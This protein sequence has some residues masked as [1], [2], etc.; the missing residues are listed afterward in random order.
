M[1]P[2]RILRR[3]YT[4]N[5]T[6]ALNKLTTELATDSP[7][8]IQILSL[9]EQVQS[10][11]QRLFD[12]ATQMQEEMDDTALEA[13]IE[14]MDD[15]ENRV[16][17]VKVKAQAV[18]NQM[19]Q[20]KV[21]PTQP[22]YYQPPVSAKLPDATLQEFHGDVEM[23]PSFIDQFNAL[24]DNNKNLT[25]VEKFSYLRGAAK[26]EIIQHYP[27]TSSNYQVALERL[28]REFGDENL[29][30]KKHLN[31]LLDMSKRKQP[32]SNQEIQEFYNFLE[33]K[34]TCL[35]ALNKPVDQSNEMLITLI[36]RQLPKKLKVQIAK[37]DAA[38]NTVQSVMNI[39]KDYINTA[40][41]ME[42]REECEIDSDDDMYNHKAAGYYKHKT[43]IDRDSDEDEG[44]ITS[45]AAALP[46]LTQKRRPCT[47]CHD[48]HS[49]SYC[50]KV[51]NIEQRRQVLWRENRCFNCLAVGHR[52]TDCRNDGRCQT[53]QGKHHS[54]LC[55]N[56]LQ[57]KYGGKETQQMQNR[58]QTSSNQQQQ[59]Y[60]GGGGQNTWGRKPTSTNTGVCTTSSWE[61][62]NSVLLELAEAEIRKPGSSKSITVNV[63][64]DHGAQKSYVKTA[65]RKELALDGIRRDVLEHSVFGTEETQVSSS[66]FVMLEIVKGSF[67][68]EIPV[69]VSNHICNPLPSFKISSRKLQELKGVTLA[70]PRC[71]YEESH[72]ISVLIGGDLYWEF[73]GSKQIRTSFG[74]CA[75]QSKL[76]WLL[77]GP[78]SGEEG[79]STNVYLTTS[80]VI[81]SMKLDEVTID[82]K[83]VKQKLLNSH[84]NTCLDKLET[85]SNVA[86]ATSQHKVQGQSSEH[87]VVPVV[88]Q[89]ASQTQMQ[90]PDK[91]NAHKIS[92]LSA[93][94]MSDNYN[95]VQ[96]QM[97][98][99]VEEVDDWFQYKMQRSLTDSDVELRWF[100]ETE[101]IA[102]I[103][104][105]E[106]PSVLEEF[107][108]NIKYDEDT[109][110]YTVG[111]PSKINMLEGL[112]D[113][114][115]ICEIR[116]QSLLNKLNK[117]GNEETRKAYNEIIKKQLDEGIIEE[118]SPDQCTDAV[119]HY[120]PHHAVLRK[121][122]QSSK[123]RIVYD[124]SAKA[125]RESS[126]L[127]QCLKPGPSLVNNLVAVL[128]MFRM[129]LIGVVADICQAYLQLLLSLND[130]D[131]TRFLWKDGGDLNNPT[132]IFRFTRVPF[133]LTSSP[134][135]LHATLIHHLNKYKEGY[136]EIVTKLLR[137]IYVDDLV[138]GAD[139]EDEVVELVNQGDVIIKEAN[140]EFKKWRSNSPHVLE[141]S[142]VPD[143]MK[144]SEA[145]IKVLGVTWNTN[146]DQFTYEV[147][148]IIDLAESL[149]PCKRTVLRIL[150]KVYDPLGMLSP[151]LITAKVL[152][153]ML[154]RLNLSWDQPLEEDFIGLWNRWVA[155]LRILKEFK[156]PRCI[157]SNAHSELELVGF[158]DASKDAY[159]A[160]VYLRCTTK[161]SIT[162]N[163][164]LAKSRVA[165]MKQLTIPRL[166]LLGAV[167]LA[168]MISLL[169]EIL[170]NWKFTNV[171]HYT[172]SMN[173][174]GWIQSE[175]K[176]N[177]YITKRLDEIL[178]LSSKLKWYHCKGEENPADYPTRGMTMDQLCNSTEWL[179][180]PQ[181]LSTA[182]FSP[183]RNNT[184]IVPSHE[185]L[186]EEIKQVHTH[187]VIEEAGL[188]KLIKLD[189]YSNLGRLYR[190][191]AYVYLFIKQSQ[192]KEVSLIDMKRLA[193]TKWIINQQMK[194]N[195]NLVPY[196]KGDVATR[197]IN[198]AKQLD[199]FLDDKGIMRCSGRFKYANLCYRLK[200]P[201]FMPR[202]SHLTT[203]IIRDR[204]RRVKHAGV[205]TTLA[206]VR[207]DYWI[208]RGRRFIQTIIRNCVICRR[209]TAKPFPAP[210]P[211]PLPKIRLSEMPPFTNT[212]VDFAGP[213]YCRERGRGKKPYKSYIS[214]YTCASARAI[215]L[216]LVPNMSASSFKNSM[217]RFVSTRGIPHC[218]VSDN[219]KS[220]K[221]TAEDLNCIIT[222]SPTKE[223]IEDNNITWLFYL[224]KSPWWGGFI[225]RMVGSVKRVLKKVLYRTFLSYDE[226]TTLLKQ[227]ES[228]I[229]SRPITQMFNDDIEEP[230]TPSHL[231]IGKRSTQLP[232]A[233][234][235]VDDSE[236]RNRYREQIVASFEKR[237]KKEYLSELQDYHIRNQSSKDVDV[238]PQIGEVVI[239]KENKPRSSW[240]LCKVTNIFKG[241]D[242]KVRSV[243]VIKPNK[244]LARRP[245][246]LL[247]PLECKYNP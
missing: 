95:K 186:K 128:L 114:Y 184:Q 194:H 66:D 216:E 135:L 24:V 5:V 217:I 237:W 195:R 127:N 163:F 117:P 191:T 242:G 13:D 65:L 32:S 123:V 196:L 174:L 172:D 100:W 44:G 222:R 223:F 158:C 197:P 71:K 115:H 193:E 41:Q 188:N 220:F 234:L 28:K 105:D 111:F 76:G 210:G 199:L 157:K 168:R 94:V 62:M 176:W 198:I 6:G 30:A 80:K 96:K 46:V 23:F 207:E 243:E 141:R 42:Y 221:K 147:N 12:I 25:D 224:E 91:L 68:K 33:T 124:G 54:S 40:K 246:Q 134:F 156:V 79:S 36:Y 48:N 139:D 81:K 129:F 89:N 72:E 201:I 133:G 26:V 120:L 142:N 229:N 244:N 51:Q 59:R 112:Q 215:Q 39:I 58:N 190:V 230:L 167:L 64:L 240:N 212:G 99:E 192:K 106:E 37:L 22:V 60:G 202:E 153:Q 185:C 85:I 200:Y 113:N 227:I 160:V 146:T 213:V 137:S 161:T 173:V 144:S 78:V 152:L 109:K 121:D 225:E 122:K 4:L 14:E 98:D 175:K 52:G 15:L 143:A 7:N 166:E 151:Y 9:L 45:S 150:Q 31:A 11:F 53:C 102:I 88:Y 27:L 238:V 8:E 84:P 136:P 55:N 90:Q 241:K 204:H 162:S 233:T 206:E 17:E 61:S 219:A 140:M 18:L 126:S 228:I 3:T 38:H 86:N 107:L 1:P 57:Q 75:V 159:A 93:L 10:K 165:P 82:K 187:V 181:W 16:I 183:E 236:E 83:W 169:M 205:K 182:N 19:K 97:T 149:K 239:M 34:L 74:V 69:H 35:E 138:S 211:P 119:I 170:S 180:G 101:H 245:P 50:H 116:L 177:R 247:I 47:Y 118:V 164:I 218:M 56:Q 21:E 155:D 171:I 231:L 232:T 103:P 92:T 203:L 209:L 214:L 108:Q 208:P 63:F 87:M 226:M 104:E 235:Y 130:R 178:K 125:N 110:T 73:V 189:D 2:K 179:H 29:I 77:S 67:R 154:C 131:L 43:E 70:H 49:P 132:K 148:N 20:M 145:T